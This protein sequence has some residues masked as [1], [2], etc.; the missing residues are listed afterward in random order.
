MKFTVNPLQS[1]IVFG[2]GTAAQLPEEIATLGGTRNN[3]WPDAS[4][5]F[6]NSQANPLGLV[7]MQ[8]AAPTTGIGVP[9]CACYSDATNVRFRV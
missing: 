7:L 6:A 4:W 9:N 2:A 3:Y 8:W 5:Q 1:R